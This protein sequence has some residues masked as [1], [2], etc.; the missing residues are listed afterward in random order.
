MET[1]TSAK[2]MA[3]AVFKKTKNDLIKAAKKKDH[4]IEKR[5]NKIQ[6]GMDEDIFV[7]FVL[8]DTF[9]DKF[10]DGEIVGFVDVSG[11][12]DGLP[13]G[14][15][16]VKMYFE[17]KNRNKPSEFINVTTG[18]QYLFETDTEKIEASV[19]KNTCEFSIKKG[20]TWINV[21][22][23]L[24]DGTYIIRKVCLDCPECY[25]E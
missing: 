25:D 16:C 1:D 24:I 18:E 8:S 12:G 21:L 5:I 23:E 19:A 10:S 17:E 13:D 20:C 11:F 2:E 7:S 4:L 3:S 6:I 15:Y 14:Q 9:P 22:I